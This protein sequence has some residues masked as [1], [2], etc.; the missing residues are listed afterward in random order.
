MLPRK[1]LAT[2]SDASW[3][4][5]IR[6]VTPG[7]HSR[8]SRNVNHDGTRTNGLQLLDL[9]TESQTGSNCLHGVLDTTFGW[10]TGEVGFTGEQ[11]ACRCV[12]WLVLA[13]VFTKPLQASSCL[14]C[15]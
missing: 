5:P 11:V 3:Q 12:Q 8:V 1:V 2:P 4:S 10:S 7:S 14:A 6:C 9:H 13:S 15:R